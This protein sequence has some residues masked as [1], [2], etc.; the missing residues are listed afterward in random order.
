M[1]EKITI[2]WEYYRYMQLFGWHKR[3]MTFPPL[4]SPILSLVSRVA[5]GGELVERGCVGRKKIFAI[6]V[7]DKLG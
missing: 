5:W 1:R 7:Y 6:S 2:K 3:N 4:L